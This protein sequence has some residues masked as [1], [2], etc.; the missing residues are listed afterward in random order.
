M[1]TAARVP[2]MTGVAATTAVDAAATLEITEAMTGNK[3]NI[4]ISPFTIEAFV[5]HFSCLLLVL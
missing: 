5:I 3:N 4:S 2:P 1:V